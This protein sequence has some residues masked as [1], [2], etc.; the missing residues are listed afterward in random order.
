MYVP[1]LLYSNLCPVLQRTLSCICTFRPCFSL[2]ICSGVELQ[3]FMVS[4]FLV[5][6]G[7]LH[8]AF[9]RAFP[10]CIPTNSV[11]GFPSLHTLSSIY[12]GFFD[13]SHSGWCEVTSLCSFHWRLSQLAMLSLFSCVCWSFVCLFFRGMSIQVFC[14]F[15]D[16][17]VRWLQKRW[18][19]TS[20]LGYFFFSSNHGAYLYITFISLQALALDTVVFC[21]AF[22]VRNYTL[23]KL[24]N[25]G[26]SQS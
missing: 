5:F 11:G 22:E 9:Q 1:H 10:I 2:D 16:W 24:I 19:L 13:E 6:L 15:V 3:G 21:V 23:M 4:L 7:N 18:I 12:C 17:V 26:L 8:T 14:P 25:F 20:D